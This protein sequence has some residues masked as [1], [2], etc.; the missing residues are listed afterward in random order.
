MLKYPRHIVAA[1]AVVMNQEG[2]IL[3]VRTRRREWEPPGGQVELGEDIEMGLKREVREESG[4]EVEV[5][6]LIG[7][8][9]NVGAPE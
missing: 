6:R 5:G 2:L 8:Y 1:M 7:V 9:S 4:C 3:L